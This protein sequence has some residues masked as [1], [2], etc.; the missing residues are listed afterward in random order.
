MVGLLAGERAALPGQE[1]GIRW[2]HH[3]LI[4][5]QDQAKG[6]KKIVVS[7]KGGENVSVAMVRDLAHVVVREK[8]D[9]GLFVTLTAATKPMMVE[10]VKEGYYTSPDTGKAFPKLQI[11]TIEGLLHGKERALYPDLSQG[12]TTFKKAKIE[13]KAVKQTGLF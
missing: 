8:A 13:E 10:A 1:K 7:V 12:S 4:F 2:R 11:L 9:M 6:H 3:G 5:F